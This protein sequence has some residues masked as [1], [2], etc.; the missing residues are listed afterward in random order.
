MVSSSLLALGG[1]LACACLRAA[2][3]CSYNGPFDLRKIDPL[4]NEVDSV[5]LIGKPNIRCTIAAQQRLQAGNVCNTFVDATADPALFSYMKCLHPETDMHSFVYMRGQYIGDGF[6]LLS[7]RADWRCKRK[8]T[9]RGV[10]TTVD[11]LD[12]GQF[13]A[14]LKA[15][16]SSTNCLPSCD[17]IKDNV[18]PAR[19]PEMFNQN[20]KAHSLMLYGWNGC[21]CTSYARSHFMSGAWCYG[22]NVWSNPSDP[23]F[24]YLQC[25]YGSQHHSFVF[26]NGQFKG[27][28]FGFNMGDARA[29]YGPDSKLTPMLQ[30]ANTQR[31]CPFLGLSNLRGTGLKACTKNNDKH[32]TGWTRSGSCNWDANDG[33]YHEVCVEMTKSF[34]RTSASDD[35]NDLSSVVQQGGH[36]CICAWAFA[37]AVAHDP[38]GIQGI[39]LDCNSTNGNLRKVYTSHGYLRA[40]SGLTY[41]SQAALA[42]VDE[43]CP[44]PGASQ[45]DFKPLLAACAHVN[46]KDV[47]GCSSV[48]A[49]ESAKLTASCKAHN[50]AIGRLADKLLAT[51]AQAKSQISNN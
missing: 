22:E 40:P 20:I 24:A 30:A 42:K 2:S 8:L 11:C 7:N 27:N 19:F 43:L 49:E 5:V 50:P 16:A 38:T 45:C 31:T 15:A 3:A 10:V 23:L 46:P 47:A 39:K 21:P 33:G 41:K 35:G 4:D 37:S 14:Q 34:L 25:R 13:T 6:R 44:L 17:H 12:H 28:G 1:A 51:C 29:P 26:V 36:W 9:V 48:C 32:A 18:V